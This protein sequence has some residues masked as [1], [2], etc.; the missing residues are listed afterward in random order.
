MKLRNTMSMS[1][2]LIQVWPYILSDLIW[3]KTVYVC[4]QQTTL[5]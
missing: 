3:V 4:Y 2:I 5:A 1:N